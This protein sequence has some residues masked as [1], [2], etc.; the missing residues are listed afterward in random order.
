LASLVE[1][2]FGAPEDSSVQYPRWLRQVKKD[3]EDSDD[4]IDQS[5]WDISGF[6]NA[7]FAKYEA[8]FGFRGRPKWTSELKPEEMAIFGMCRFA[9]ATIPYSWWSN[10]EI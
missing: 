9:F 7:A 1:K 2:F 10:T 6:D 8:I 4:P 3:S 5:G